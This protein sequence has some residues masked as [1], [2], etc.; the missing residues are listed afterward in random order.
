[1]TS[2]D[3]HSDIRFELSTDSQPQAVRRARRA[4]ESID[5]LRIDAQLAF[6]VRLL[7]SEL[8]T[9]AV[10]HGSQHEQEQ[11][12]LVHSCMTTAS[13]SRSATEDPA[14]SLDRASPKQAA[15]NRLLAA[16]YSC[17]APS[18]TATGSATQSTAARSGSKSTS[19]N[20]LSIPRDLRLRGRARRDPTFRCRSRSSLNASPRCSQ[21]L[22][23]RDD[24]DML[25]DG[26]HPSVRVAVKT[27]GPSGS[28]DLALC[29]TRKSTLLHGKGAS[30][31]GGKRWQTPSL[32]WNFA[33]NWW[34]PFATVGLFSPFPRPGDLPLIA[35]GCNHGAP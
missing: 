6:N 20:R 27:C 34:Q 9:N 35:T 24:G 12:T 31:T 8:V 15:S 11:I 17:S 19:P 32:P 30:A 23:R 33:R 14:S 21:R 13:A 26:G 4:I 7:V 1:V 25:L 2:Q 28:Q 5:E 16:A 10:T 18:P 22:T 29:G 3:S